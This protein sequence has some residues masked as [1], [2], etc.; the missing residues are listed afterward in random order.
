[1]N[2]VSYNFWIV[3]FYV[4][5]VSFI[6]FVGLMIFL[7]LRKN[8]YL[9][10]YVV[11]D[12]LKTYS[13]SGV[14]N[15]IYGVNGSVKNFIK[16]YVIRKSN[17]DTSFIA[18]YQGFHTI[19]SYFVVCYDKKGKICGVVQVSERDNNETGKIIG[20]P[21]RTHVVNI[22][23][24]KVDD[25]ELA[26]SIIKPISVKRIRIYSLL[27]ALSFFSL[28]FIIRHLVCVIIAPDYLRE[29]Y[30]SF[31]NFYAFLGMLLMTVIIYF[32]SVC[33]M[34][35]KNSKN[36]SGGIKYEFN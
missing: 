32:I 31:W 5:I 1:M 35:R 17:Y 25:M 14:K 10:S 27:Y 20:L 7:K 28:A 16:R 12:V 11:D 24:K 3:L 6:L 30:T 4:S 13:E 18:N 26:S 21:H 15:E 36:R 23:M 9:H 8:E 2:L 34:R 29:Y 22:V 33:S 19:I